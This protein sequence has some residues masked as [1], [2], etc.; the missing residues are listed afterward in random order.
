MHDLSLSTRI[1]V[2]HF[3]PDILKSWDVLVEISITIVLTGI[4]SRKTFCLKSKTFNRKI[5]L[6]KN[7]EFKG[8]HFWWN[9]FCMPVPLLKTGSIVPM[10]K[11][12]FIV[13]VILWICEIIWNR[14]LTEQL[15]VAVSIGARIVHDINLAIV[16]VIK[17]V[18]VHAF[19]VNLRNV[20]C[21][22]VVW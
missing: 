19:M 6:K 2:D 4:T 18:L 3:I 16:L 7:M 14:S 11:K 17:K 13:G 9:P 22:L 20:F 15:L 1:L 8:K 21:F 10:L 12:A 5:F